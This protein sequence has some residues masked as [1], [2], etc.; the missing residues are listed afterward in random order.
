MN[1][2]AFTAPPPKYKKRGH[3]DVIDLVG[4]AIRKTANDGGITVSPAV[5]FGGL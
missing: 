3:G 1:Y 2:A 4:P 5:D